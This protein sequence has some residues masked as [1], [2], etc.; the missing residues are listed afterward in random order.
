MGGKVRASGLS[1][2]LGGRINFAALDAARKEEE[3]INYGKANN[4]FK[5]EEKSKI[6]Q[7]LN[8]QQLWKETAEEKRARQDED[9]IMVVDVRGGGGMGVLMAEDSQYERDEFG[10]IIFKADEDDDDEEDESESDGELADFDD[11]TMKELHEKRRER[12]REAKERQEQLRK[13]AAAEKA[14]RETEIERELKEIEMKEAKL[15][16]GKMITDDDVKAVQAKL[17]SELDFGTDGFGFH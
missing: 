15:S 14:A 1:N 10:N 12:E 3:K 11:D 8:P 4:N 7:A 2:R 16:K 6:F 17:E 9:N 5:Q 13:Q